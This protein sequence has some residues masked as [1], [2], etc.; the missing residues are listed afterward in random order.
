MNV[1]CIAFSR[2]VAEILLKRAQSPVGAGRVFKLRL[3][4]PNLAEVE[5]KGAFSTAALL[6]KI[7]SLHQLAVV[8]KSVQVKDAPRIAL[9]PRR[10]PCLFARPLWP[11]QCVG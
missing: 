3:R 1:C 8:C 7:K 2:P 4:Q 9:K 5:E 11:Q 6:Q 10:V